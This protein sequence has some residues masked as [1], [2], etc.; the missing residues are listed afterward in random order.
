MTNLKTKLAVAA[1]LVGTIAASAATPSYARDRALA[2]AGIGFAAGAV[3]GAAAVN[4]NNG[5]Y[6]EPGYAPGYAYE[7]AP[8]YGYAYVPA[9]GYAYA[10]RVRCRHFVNETNCGEHEK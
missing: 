5:Y 1:L 4:A 7:P 10:P 2:A 3:I 6:Y 9:Y 8:A